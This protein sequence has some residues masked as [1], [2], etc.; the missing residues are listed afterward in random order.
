MGTSV[1]FS[2]GNLSFGVIAPGASG[3]QSAQSATLTAAATVSASISNDTSGGAIKVSTLT[4]YVIE[5]ITVTPDPGEI[6]GGGRPKPVRVPSA[7]QVAQSVGGASLAVASGQY[8]V[9]AIEFAPISSTPNSC[10]ATLQIE[11]ATWNTVSI[12]VTASVGALTVEVPAISVTQGKSTEAP[13]TVTLTAGANT[14]ANLSVAAYSSLPPTGIVSLASASLSLSKGVPATTNLTVNAG[15]LATGTYS[16]TLGVSAYGG[17]YTT[18][19]MINITVE[20]PYFV[21]K[22]A[23]GTVIELPTTSSLLQTAADPTTPSDGQLWCFVPDP[24]GSGCYFIKNKLNGNV[25]DIQGASTSPGA[26]LDAYQQKPSGTDNQ[27]WYFVSSPTVIPATKTDPSP[28]EFAFIVSKLN[29]NVVDIQGGSTAPG[30][31]LDA[32]PVKLFGTNNQLWTVVGGSFP[33]VA[34]TVPQPLLGLATGNSNYFIESDSEALTGA[35]VTVTITKDFVSSANGWGF[36]LNC[37][38]TEGPT[39]TTSWQQF[40]IYATPGS[41]QVMAAVNTWGN[42]PARSE[43]NIILQPLATL[44]SPT[45]PKGYSLNIA[46]TYLGNSEGYT[47]DPTSII[48]G[49]TYSVTDDKGNSVGS[50]TISIVGNNLQTTGNPATAANLAPIA[51]MQLNICGD[52]NKAQATL[53]GGAGKITYGADRGGAGAKLYEFQ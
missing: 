43:L 47:I 7:V 26:L 29:G 2:P 46:L 40:V 23:V 37:Y 33:S 9:A 4:S 41:N 13:V 1:S 51:A 53:T 3:T 52:Y 38:S 36:Q 25:I 34:P 44:P 10:S 14:T 42:P 24:A 50:T 12:P 17:A 28:A 8:V 19:A 11:A 21:I 22:S 5:D 48:S 30:I 27:L 31:G 35:W 20:Q 49:A 15:T 6:L 45:I 18:S 39:V 16:F 32:F